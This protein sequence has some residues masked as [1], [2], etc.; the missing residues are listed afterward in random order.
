MRKIL[1]HLRERITQMF[2]QRVPDGHLRYTIAALEGIRQSC[3]KQGI[4]PADPLDL[5]EYLVDYP[6]AM[7]VYSCIIVRGAMGP[8]PLYFMRS[9][10]WPDLDYYCHSV[11]AAF[12]AWE[13]AQSPAPGGGK[14]I[15]PNV[16][17]TM[18]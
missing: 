7:L 8:D 17:D 18:N 9:R 5:I 1:M 12:V 2:M 3:R 14:I 6:E 16:G 13:A 10:C 4:M 15:A 11:D